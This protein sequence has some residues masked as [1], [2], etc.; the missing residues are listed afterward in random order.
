VKGEEVREDDLRYR[1]RTREVIE[2]RRLFCQLAVRKMGYCGGD[3]AR[4][5]GVTTSNAAP[6]RFSL[7]H[8]Y[9]D[10]EQFRASATLPGPNF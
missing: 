10:F 5:L 8:I 1:N 7:K 6:F 4:F 2:A 3:V 9:D